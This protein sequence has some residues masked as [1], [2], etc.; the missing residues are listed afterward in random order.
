VFIR[1]YDSATTIGGWTLR[2]KAEHLPE[3]LQE[4]ALQWYFQNF[5]GQ[6]PDWNFL[7]LKFMKCFTF[8]IL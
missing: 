2:E 8:D 5:L 4:K 7:K 3:H 1:A 6:H